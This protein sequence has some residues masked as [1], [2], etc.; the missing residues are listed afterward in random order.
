MVFHFGML[1]FAVCFLDEHEPAPTTLPQFKNITRVND[2]DCLNLAWVLKFS[3]GRHDHHRHHYCDLDSYSHRGGG[4]WLQHFF[5]T[6][7]K[8]FLCPLQT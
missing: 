3:S 5:Q 4:G 7:A 6:P 1:V 8:E 2:A